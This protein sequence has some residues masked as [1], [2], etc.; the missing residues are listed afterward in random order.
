[1]IRLMEAGGGREGRGGGLGMGVGV[2]TT[3]RMDKQEGPTYGTGSGVW[4]PGVSHNGKDDKQRMCVY[5]H[6]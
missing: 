3:C 2:L 5:I 6:V 1:M 4:P